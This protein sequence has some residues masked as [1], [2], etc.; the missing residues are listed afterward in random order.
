MYLIL[1]PDSPLHSST[2]FQRLEE[3]EGL[4]GV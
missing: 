3:A 2:T 4:E 1:R